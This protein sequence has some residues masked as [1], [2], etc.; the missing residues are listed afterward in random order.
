MILAHEA[1]GILAPLPGTKPTSPTLEGEVLP[2]GPVGKSQGWPRI[3]NDTKWARPVI[4]LLQ[5]K[6]KEWRTNSQITLSGIIYTS[7]QIIIK[8]NC[9]G[10][11]TMT[12]GIK[13]GMRKTFLSVLR[14]SAVPEL[15]GDVPT[16]QCLSLGVMSLLSS[17]WAWGW[18]PL[19]PYTFCY[20]TCAKLRSVWSQISLL[21]LMSS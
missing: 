15:G 10:D 11:N 20:F 8:E 17:A 1:C 19:Y 4:M 18:C 12:K 2:T 9:K 16:Q 6:W 7:F 21:I 3:R 14:H 5:G 13:R